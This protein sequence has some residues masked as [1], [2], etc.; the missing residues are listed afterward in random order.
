ML[1]KI[2]SIS[3]CVQCFI[4]LHAQERKWAATI[5]P[6]V[7]Q[8]PE[9]YMAIQPGMQYRPNSRVAVVVEVCI[10]VFAFANNTSI[11]DRTY[12][13]LK[14]ELKYNLNS[15]PRSPYISI[16]SSYAIREFTAENSAY[17][18]GGRVDSMFSYQR[19]SVS[20]PIWIT[21]LKIGREYKLGPHFAVDFF[22]GLGFRNINT[23]YSDIKEVTGP[24]YA[25]LQPVCNSP[26]SDPAWWY[27]ANI[28]RF[29]ATCGF[30]FMYQF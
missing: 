15:S 24:T 17:F 22:A 18:T 7:V 5:S 1:K 11:T 20:S 10:P 14:G 19:A 3:L 4:V 28:Y 26:M 23:Q 6:A 16:E 30:R 12:S 21:N 8:M 9:L 2:L 13:R 25:R 29:N 27:E